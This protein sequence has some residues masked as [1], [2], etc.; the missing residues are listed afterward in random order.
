MTERNLGA[1]F[2]V[3]LG[4][5]TLTSP[6]AIHLFLPAMPDVKAGFDA[7]DALVQATFSVTFLA[8][9]VAT[10]VY[11]SLSDR[12]GRR[13]V[14]LA[15]LGLF[16]L[17]S[18]ASALAVSIFTLIAGRLVQALGAACG[19]TLARAIAR[20]AYGPA[21]LVKAIAYLTMAYTLGPM[22]APTAGGLLIDNFGWRSVFWFALAAGGAIAASSYFVLVETHARSGGGA[23]SGVLRHYGALLRDQRFIAFILQPGFMSFMFFAVAAAS[24]F[25][26]KDVLGRS[27]TE[28]GLYFMCFPAGYCSGNLISSRLSGRVA[29]ETMVLAGALVCLAAAVA[30]AACVLAGLL[31]PLIIFVPGGVMSF[32]QGLSL[33]NAQAGAMRI[34]PELAGTAAGLGVFVQMLLSALSS[35]LYGFLADGTALP[36]IWISSAGVVFAVAAAVYSYVKRGADAEAL[37]AAAPVPSPRR[38]ETRI[39]RA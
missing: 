5:I 13:P 20:D 15:G 30:Q 28:Y 7:S 39:G 3:A 8:M 24:P 23:S 25:L 21:A 33:P 11:G 29:I 10:P 14:L 37:A 36:M 31:S 16:L 1:G 4:A 32:A 17:G 34:R 6:L 12:Y 26:M 2:V 27:E 9:A 18:L 38:P 19:L 35:Q 22:V